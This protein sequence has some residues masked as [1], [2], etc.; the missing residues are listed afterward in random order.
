MRSI[1]LDDTSHAQGGG[2]F[3]QCTG[4]D[5][6]RLRNGVASASDGQDTIVDT[7]HDL[8][9]TSL[10][11][12]LVAQLCHVLATLA[13]DDAGLFGGDDGAEG[14]LRLG[15]LLVGAG[16]RLAVGAKTA[17]TIFD[18]DAVHADGQVVAVGGKVVLMGRHGNR[19]EVEDEMKLV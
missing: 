13:D 6:V 19:W 18:L 9:D 4:D 14:E 17:L 10:D 8:G 12:G 7:L 15:V 16:G 11:A 2:P 5:R 3:Q 1:V